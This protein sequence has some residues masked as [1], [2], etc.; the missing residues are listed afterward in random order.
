MLKRRVISSAK[1][2][3]IEI[4][5]ALHLKERRKQHFQLLPNGLYRLGL[6][7][8]K[9]LSLLIVVLPC[10]MSMLSC[11][12]KTSEE[13][14]TSDIAF[15]YATLLSV[16]RTDS[17]TRVD[18]ADP[19]HKG[20][21][22]ATYLL[23][24]SDKPLPKH[25]PQGIIVRTPLKRAVAFSAVHAALAENLGCIGQIIGVCDADYICSAPLRK[26][27]AEGSLANFG[28]AMQPA[29]EQIVAHKADGL[30]ISPFRDHVPGPVERIGIPVIA[31]AD[32][33]ETSP[34]GR[35]EWMRFYGML[36][37]CEARADSLFD[38]V[39]ARYMKWKAIATKAK[40]HPT[41]MVDLRTGPVWYVAGGRSTMGRLYADAGLAYLFAS[42]TVSGSVPLDFER[43]YTRCSEADYWFMKYGNATDY[44]YAS[45]AANDA[46]YKRFKPWNERHIV[47][48]NTLRTPFYEET[49]F[50]PDKLLEEF[51]QTFHP[52]LRASDFSAKYIAPL[53][54]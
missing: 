45:I 28:Q 40:S 37:G 38:E 42:D 27:L 8:A 54:E 23:I 41:L 4:I 50:H 5:R 20:Q 7:F 33:M 10:G 34:L 48:C 6:H 53:T 16:G 24:P 25:L 3:V 26:A 21:T 31:C 19:W 11:H 35:A 18:I 29:I 9:A 17:F 14:T 13:A 52:E 32:Y 22:A 51:V 39:E 43:V 2:V 44:T 46:R 1:A 12:G 30:L 47:G 49:P 15:R 36:L